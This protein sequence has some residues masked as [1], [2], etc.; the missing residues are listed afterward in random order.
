M[1]DGAYDSRADFRYLDRKGIEPVIK[2]RKNSSMKAHGC[3]PRKLVVDGAAERLREMEDEA[4][5]REQGEGR[6]RD[7]VLQ[8][9]VRGA[10][11][12]GEVGAA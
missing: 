12:V 11:N 6:V 5:V 10:H 8:E 9:D 7:I 4:R 1:G 3:M 2:V